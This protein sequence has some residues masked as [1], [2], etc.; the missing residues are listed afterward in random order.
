MEAALV[1]EI[2]E[3]FQSYTQIC[4]MYETQ[5]SILGFAQHLKESYE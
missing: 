2:N 1:R 5:P 4:A 3:Q